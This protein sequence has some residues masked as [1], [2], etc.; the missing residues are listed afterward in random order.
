MNETV[1]PLFGL[2]LAPIAFPWQT[3]LRG[4]VGHLAFGE[5]AEVV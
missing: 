5:V 2:T 1:T 4:L 3:Y